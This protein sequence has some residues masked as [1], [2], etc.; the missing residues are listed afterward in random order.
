MTESLYSVA[1][2]CHEVLKPDF[3]ADEFARLAAGIS[4][5]I[6]GASAADGRQVAGYRLPF[7]KGGR[8]ADDSGLYHSMAPQI[9][10]A[11]RP[12]AH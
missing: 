4:E 6:H 7:R 12:A 5:R 8:Y 10:R 3:S 11:S 9:L 1:D 2:R